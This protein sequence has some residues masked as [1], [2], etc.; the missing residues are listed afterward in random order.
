MNRQHRMQ[1]RIDT[2]LNDRGREQARTAAL[3]LRE[4]KIYPNRVLVSPL[5][6]ARETAEIVSGM[7]REQQE[8][9]PRIVE[10]SFGVAEGLP[11]EE[12]P[13]R[14][15]ETFFKSV[16]DYEPPKGAESYTALFWGFSSFGGKLRP[17]NF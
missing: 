13:D 17:G 12:L 11:N 8:V 3:F 4:H 7:P 15:Y 14:F 9:D 2:Q 16:V 5:D 10:M 1:G 6:R